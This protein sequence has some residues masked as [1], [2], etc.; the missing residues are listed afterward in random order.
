MMGGK[1]Y[2]RLYDAKFKTLSSECKSDLYS[3]R[4]L[5]KECNGW[6]YAAVDGPEGS[7][8]FD[9]SSCT[10]ASGLGDS[11]ITWRPVPEAGAGCELTDVN[12]MICVDNHVV[13]VGDFKMPVYRAGW[14]DTTSWNE[15]DSWT[16]ESTLQNITESPWLGNTS[17]CDVQSSCVEVCE[18]E[19]SSHDRPWPALSSVAQNPDEDWYWLGGTPEPEVADGA[20]VMRVNLA[21]S[22]PVVYLS[23]IHI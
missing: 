5:T 13:A 3:I 22:P 16:V 10:S 7:K 8:R 19:C 17:C 9:P 18:N 15:S 11:N 20:A 1:N 21:D 6:V 2:F 23:L 14:Y 4:A 12:D